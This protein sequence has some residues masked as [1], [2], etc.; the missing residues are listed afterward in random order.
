M[1]QALTVM[2]NDGLQYESGLGTSW[3]SM[4]EGA[5][6][7][8]QP[9]TVG[10]ASKLA[11]VLTAISTA[12]PTAIS[13]YQAARQPQ[14]PIQQAPVPPPPQQIRETEDDSRSINANVGFSLDKGLNIGGIQ[15]PVLF[16]ALGAAGLY[17]LF[18]EPPR[19]GR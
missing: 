7:A 16:L 13:S 3:K 10:T 12:I 18:K 11:S 9:A 1:N 4:I 2:A 14:L 8:S 19:R 6:S 15:I 17:L 5:S